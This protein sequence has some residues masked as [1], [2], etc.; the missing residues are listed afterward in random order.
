VPGCLTKRFAIMGAVATLLGLAACGVE[1]DEKAIRPVQ[2]LVDLLS[3]AGE[4][5]RATLR[6]ETRSVLRGH[7]E[8]ELARGF[9]LRVSD[10]ARLV[11]RAPLGGDFDGVERCVIAPAV[12]YGPR[13][14]SLPAALAD[15]STGADGRFVDVDLRLPPA[16][17]GVEATFSLPATALPASDA[18]R[19]ET[20]V[21]EIP[22]GATLDFGMG[23]L[24]P[25]ARQGPVEFSLQVCD[26][27]VCEQIFAE[28][29]DSKPP[30][31]LGWVDRSISLAEY[32]GVSRVFRFETVHRPTNS[33]GYSLPVWSNP[34]IF[35][36]TASPAKH[37][38]IILLSIDTLRADHLPS[39]GYPLDTAPFIDEKL[40]AEGTLFESLV[41][42][43]TTTGPAHISMLTALPPSAHRRTS[44][45]AT[46]APEATMLAEA[47]RR[48]GFTTAAITEN[49][50]M[51]VAQFGRGFDVFAENKSVDIRR[52][53]GQV[54][55]TF[56]RAREWLLAQRGRDYF[57]LLH[58]FQV[59][60]PYAPP[61]RYA[62][63]FPQLP[64]GHEAHP[65]LSPGRDPRFYDR[66]IRF[67]DDELRSFF[68]F[69]ESEGLDDHLLFVLTS[70][71]GDA[72]L[73]HGYW[74][75]GADVHAEVTNVPLIFW[76]RGVARGRRLRE[77]V[78]HVDLMPTL[79]DLVGI[80]IPESVDGRSLANEVRGTGES[81]LIPAFSEAWY[82]VGRGPDGAT[83]IEQPTLAV[84]LGERKLVRRRGEQGFAY[85]YYDLGA[86][87]GERNDR[88]GEAEDEAQD[89]RR[90]LEAYT[91][92]AAARHTAASEVPDA[93]PVMDPERKAKLEALG[94]VE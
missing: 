38:G 84:R 72:F 91:E 32:A 85:S 56:A 86:D 5:P 75:H 14:Q 80:P 51:N 31:G 67:V 49:G 33:Q 74:G 93:E 6:D 40:A 78:G 44:N 71:H 79:L 13:W 24:A 50:P 45:F 30:K 58:T 89:L 2:R 10:D 59:H 22:P 29:L 46:A 65:R 87:P 28:I 12:R 37:T 63:L 94:Y 7:A 77:P 73:E 17:A 1:G 21:I 16:S 82:P 55:R 35:A 47:L 57:L 60:F 8:T 42:A 68:A 52:P 39:Y 69:L 90:L 3:P 27:E 76:G 62:D 54:D 66:E 9:K 64:P 23:I 70:D 83:R 20:P 11:F 88:Y 61:Q 26:G 34:T 15:V 25:A 18:S 53:S 48:N 92:S 19:I 36:P 43:A 41:A 81:K 4:P